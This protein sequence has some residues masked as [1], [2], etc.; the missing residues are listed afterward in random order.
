[1]ERGEFD[2]HIKQDCPECQI[3]CHYSQHGCPWTGKRCSYQ[4]SHSKQCKVGALAR[5]NARLQK[6][7]KKVNFVEKYTNYDCF[8]ISG[9]TGED[10][11]RSAM[12][13]HFSESYFNLGFDIRFG[14]TNAGLITIGGIVNDSVYSFN[15]KEK[16]VN[17][18]VQLDINQA[19]GVL[20]MTLN[21]RHN[22]FFMFRHKKIKPILKKAYGRIYIEIPHEIE[23]PEPTPSVMVFA[24]RR[25]ILYRGGGEYPFVIEPSS[26]YFTHLFLKCRDETADKNKKD[27]SKNK[28]ALTEQVFT[29]LQN[30][31]NV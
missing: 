1:M 12:V 29:A 20:A 7:I 31:F 22:R 25:Y 26:R 3:P 9:F 13:R 23:S 16:D 15:T 27:P 10:Q 19:G 24:H 18:C 2:K 4:S 21:G 8:I 14:D 30:F 17:N 5:E 11:E 28:D 6:A